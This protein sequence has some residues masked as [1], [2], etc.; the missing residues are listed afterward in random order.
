MT[1]ISQVKFLLFL[2]SNERY[3]KN[4][5]FYSD[6]MALI[7]LIKGYCPFF[8]IVNKEAKIPKALNLQPDI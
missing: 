2:V 7:L 3:D 8:T 5:T 4:K 6:A 1:K